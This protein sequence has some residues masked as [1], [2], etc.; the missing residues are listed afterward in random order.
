[1]RTEAHLF[2]LGVLFPD[3][4]HF[5]AVSWGQYV[6]PGDAPPMTCASWGLDENLVAHD[7][8]DNSLSSSLYLQQMSKTSFNEIPIQEMTA[9][10]EAIGLSRIQSYYSNCNLP[11][12]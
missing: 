5:W 10:K 2:L 1:M 11:I 6:M 4:G 7:S 8:C 12:Y 3:D 9:D